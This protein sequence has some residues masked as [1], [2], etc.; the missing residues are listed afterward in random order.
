[1]KNH[2]CFDKLNNL[3]LQ[4]KFLKIQHVDSESFRFLD[5]IGYYNSD[6]IIDMFH[7]IFLEISECTHSTYKKA[8]SKRNK[9]YRRFCDACN[10]L[11]K[12][13]S[14][15]ETVQNK[16][17]DSKSEFKLQC[18]ENFKVRQEYLRLK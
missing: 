12:Y 16:Y 2:F 6:L 11:E 9:F 5:Q 7:K 17:V 13:P 10:K 1:M 15:S 18:D 4:N 3:E 14:P 8:K